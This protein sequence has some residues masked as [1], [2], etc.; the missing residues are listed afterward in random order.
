MR[1]RLLQRTPVIQTVPGCPTVNH[2]LRRLKSVELNPGT[3]PLKRTIFQWNRFHK[4]FTEFYWYHHEVGLFVYWNPSATNLNFQWVPF[5]QWN[6]MDSDMD[7]RN[8]CCNWRSR[9]DTKWLRYG[10]YISAS[11]WEN[12]HTLVNRTFTEGL[13]FGGFVYIQPGRT[14]LRLPFNTSLC[15]YSCQHPP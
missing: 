9:L 6:Y 3:D 12:L 1:R 2:R 13:L 15:A 11:V 5:P 4:L 10:K 7:T 8:C 14:W